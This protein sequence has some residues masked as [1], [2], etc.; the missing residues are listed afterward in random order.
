MNPRVLIVGT[1][2]YNTKMTS[3]AFDAYFHNW[4]RENLVQIFSNTK[5]P[6]KGHCHTLY[7]ITD[8][9]ML[10]RW[11]NRKIDTG[12]VYYYEQLPEKWTDD[13]LEVGHCGIARAYRFGQRHTPLTHLLRGMLWR[14]AFWCTSKLNEW[15]DVFR[16]ECVFLAFSDDFFI[17][18]IALYAAEKYDIPI[19]S[20]IGDDYFFNQRRTVNPIYHIYKYKY[21]KLIRYV[22]AHKGSA[23]YIS[24]KI[25]D[26]Y[27]REFQLDGKTVYLTSDISRR[28]FR[29]ID[30]DKPLITYFGNVRIGRNKSLMEIADALGKIN[31]SFVL[32]VY[33]NEQ[34]ESVLS[35]MRNHPHIKLGGSIP[36]DGV[37]ERMH[38]SDIT[39]IVEGFEENEVEFSR[40][41]LSTKAAD[42]LASGVAVFAYGS[43]DCGVI[44]YMIQTRAA[45]VCTQKG[46]LVESLKGLLED[47]ELQKRYYANQTRVTEENHNLQKSC[48]AAESV[49]RN[50]I[51]KYNGEHTDAE[52]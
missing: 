21:K 41:S 14:R 46:S 49:I 33:T 36:Y 26:K 20:C 51:E 34:D 37:M 39:L 8:S 5:K 50:A 29:P 6:C 45:Q 13:D 2:P 48:T 15:M 3:R 17:N 19:V 38:E 9:R 42:A 10:M 40:Y 27:N 4:E 43:R 23:I 25:R 35:G 28:C 12:K 22:L 30:K 44:E 7:Q 31:Q 52:T 32:E 1:V 24:D 47:V 16:P 18:Q 11:F